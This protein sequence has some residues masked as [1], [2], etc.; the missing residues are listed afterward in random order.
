[1]AKRI[2]VWGH[3]S[4]QQV[5]RLH[6]FMRGSYDQNMDALV[7]HVR[8]D[9]LQGGMMNR[10]L[11]LSSNEVTLGDTLGIHYCNGTKIFPLV[12]NLGSF[13][14]FFPIKLLHRCPDPL[15]QLFHQDHSAIDG[16][17]T[18]NP[19]SLLYYFLLPKYALVIKA[20]YL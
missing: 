16:R 14:I 11:E 1:M 2:K 19:H 12:L 13:L 7:N 18:R 8:W 5:L 6:K 9:F 17:K 4:K 20:P 15:K 3:L 10:H